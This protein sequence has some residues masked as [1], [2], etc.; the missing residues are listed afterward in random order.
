VQRDRPWDDELVFLALWEGDKALA[1][2]ALAHEPDAADAFKTCGCVD[3]VQC[4][5]DGDA[6]EMVTWAREHGGEWCEACSNALATCC[7]FV[8]VVRIA[9]TKAAV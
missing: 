3:A 8:D 5:E 4:C 9:S 6:I 1:E 2:W 7:E